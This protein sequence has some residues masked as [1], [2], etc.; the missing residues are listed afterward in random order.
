MV[1]AAVVNGRVNIFRRRLYANLTP[2]FGRILRLENPLKYT[3]SFNVNRKVLHS[4]RTSRSP[5]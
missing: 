5:Y 2:A 3:R 4:A 1:N